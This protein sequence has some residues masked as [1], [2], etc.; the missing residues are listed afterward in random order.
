MNLPAGARARSNKTQQVITISNYVNEYV[1][2]I[3]RNTI[4]N[5][6]ILCLAPKSKIKTWT[7]RLNSQVAATVFIKVRGKSMH[8]T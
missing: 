4:Y 3:S 2:F 7:Q 8:I 1:Y 6:I 5:M